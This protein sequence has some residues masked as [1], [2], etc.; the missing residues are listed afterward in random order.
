[1]LLQNTIKHI[2]TTD[3]KQFNGPWPKVVI[4]CGRKSAPVY[5]T[6]NLKEYIITAS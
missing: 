5:K 6:E 4:G 2:K 1:M 3:R